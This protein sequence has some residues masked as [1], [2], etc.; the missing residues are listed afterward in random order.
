MRQDDNDDHSFECMG[1]DLD[2]DVAT[3]H[4]E[5]TKNYCLYPNIGI[6]HSPIKGRAAAAV[7]SPS[8]FALKPECATIW[9]GHF[10]SKI[11]IKIANEGGPFAIHKNINAKTKCHFSAALEND[12]TGEVLDEGTT[13]DLVKFSFEMNNDSILNSQTNE[14]GIDVHQ[15]AVN[16][17]DVLYVVVTTTEVDAGE[18][19]FFKRI[20]CRARSPPIRQVFQIQSS[21]SIRVSHFCSS[22]LL[23]TYHTIPNNPIQSNLY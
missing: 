4:P 17:G 15:D 11:I 22:I 16:P 8:S 6:V 13:S 3:F 5:A 9:K 12:T 14:L 19:Q 10:I 2:D 23:T 1:S 18:R 20:S 7:G 21:F